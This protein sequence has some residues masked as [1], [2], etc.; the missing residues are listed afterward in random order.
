MVFCSDTEIARGSTRMSANVADQQAELPLL[1][2]QY[3]RDGERDESLS[4]PA[5]A[6]AR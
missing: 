6:G 4:S 5:L 3:G 2:D 1:D